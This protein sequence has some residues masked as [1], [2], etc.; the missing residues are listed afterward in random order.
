[1]YL[2]F[3]SLE[4]LCHILLSVVGIIKHKHIKKS[5][6]NTTSSS[7]PVYSSL[8]GFSLSYLEKKRAGISGVWCCSL[9]VGMKWE[10]PASTFTKC[11]VAWEVGNAKWLPA[12]QRMF[13]AQSQ[14]SSYSSN[15]RRKT[16]NTVPISVKCLDQRC[17]GARDQDQQRRAV[18][19]GQQGPHRCSGDK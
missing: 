2:L 16:T 10:K 9:S 12:S 15:R 17:H 5:T 19:P 14:S 7:M 6:M 1:M 13:S 4:S 11:H 3:T 18:I 8:L